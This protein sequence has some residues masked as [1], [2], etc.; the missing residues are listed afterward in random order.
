VAHLSVD[1]IVRG[2]E[3]RVAKNDQETNSTREAA[4]RVEIAQELE[5]NLEDVSSEGGEPDGPLGA[6]VDAARV[7]EHRR[8]AKYWRVAGAA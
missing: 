5:V 8:Y 4:T 7:E 2:I 1:D 3:A 6:A